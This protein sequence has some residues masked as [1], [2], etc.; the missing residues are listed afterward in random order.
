[1]KRKQKKWNAYIMAGNL[2]IYLRKAM[3]TTEA[4]NWL[5]QKCKVVNTEYFMCG[6]QVFCEC[7]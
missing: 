7:K 4:V 2:K 6:T 1:M 3:T 5:Q